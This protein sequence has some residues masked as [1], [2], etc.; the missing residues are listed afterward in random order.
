MKFMLGAYR[1]LGAKGLRFV[2]YPI[3]FFFFAFAPG[4][5]SVSRAY[6]R[7]VATFYG[8]P[9]PRPLETF[10]HIVSFCYSM[11]EKIAAWSGDI[12]LDNIRFHDDGVNDLIAALEAGRGAVII[13]SHMGN[14]EILRALATH[15]KTKVTR[16]FM[17]TS[18]VDF[19]GT[20]QFNRLIEEISPNSMMNLVSARDVGVD[21]VLDLQ[22]R[23][24]AGDLLV[25]AGD[26]TSATSQGKTETLSFLGE[27]AEFP[28]GA[29][30]LASLMEAPVYFMFGVREDDM[31]P[32]S[33]YDMHV[34][35]ARTDFAG[36]RKE[37]K[38]KIRSMIEEYIAHLERLCGE[39]PLQWYNF[40]DF[41]R[42]SNK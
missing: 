33:R 4:V 13:C 27:T 20:A 18:I 12:D 14:A 42:K 15:N 31:D 37:R 9:S 36:S 26:R 22:S 34:V 35:R 32:L 41:W 16:K 17:V 25:I 24:A 2:L 10:R 28:Q 23:L 30:I 6:L 1:L 21:T 5:R 7:R 11:V 39:H 3:V 38:Q 29:F 19:S 40:Y 8:K